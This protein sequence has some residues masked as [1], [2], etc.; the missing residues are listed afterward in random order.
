MVVNNNASLCYK[1]EKKH[2][3]QTLLE[4]C[5]NEI[6][7]K[8]KENLINNDFSSSAYDHETDSDSDNETEMN[9]TRMNLINNLFKVKIVF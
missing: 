8:Q 2:H 6:K 7:K 9:L 5:K 4:E 3:P 1:S